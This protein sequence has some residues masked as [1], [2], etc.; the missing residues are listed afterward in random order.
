MLAA[1]CFNLD[2]SKTLSS[3]NGLTNLEMN[4]VAAVSCFVELQ[5]LGVLIGLHK[6]LGAAF[7]LDEAVTVAAVG[8]GNCC[9]AGYFDYHRDPQGH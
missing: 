7:H 5:S 8:I 9:Y 2:Q 1:I 4:L 6:D 3:G